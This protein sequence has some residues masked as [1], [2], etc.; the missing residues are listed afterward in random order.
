MIEELGLQKVR[1][2]RVGDENV[3]GISGGEKKRLCIGCEM[4]ADPRCFFLFFFK[5]FLNFF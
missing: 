4:I 1:Q 5:F 3:R 2:D